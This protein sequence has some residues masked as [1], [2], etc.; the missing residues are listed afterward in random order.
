[1][2]SNS[3][4]S[5]KVAWKYYL[6]FPTILLIMVWLSINTGPWVLTEKPASLL[7]WVHAIRTVFPIVILFIVGIIKLTHRKWKGSFFTPV[8]LWWLYGLIGFFAS[9]FS[10]HPFDAI[11]WAIA[12]LSVFGVFNLF[13]Q[14]KDVLQRAVCLNYLSWFIMTVV[15]AFLFIMAR[16]VM[17]IETPFGLSG[18]EYINIMPTF[19]EMSMSRSTGLARFAAVPGI[20]SFVFLWHGG[21]WRRLFWLAM[22][23]ASGVLIYLMQSR[24][25]FFG[26]VSALSFVMLFLDRKSRRIGAV[27]LIFSI[28]FLY[29]DIIPIQLVKNAT[30]FILRGENTEELITS[31]SGRTTTWMIAWEEVKKSPI[32]GWGFQSDRFLLEQH[33]HNTY[34]Y[35]LMTAGFVGAF[36]FVGGLLKAWI[37]FFQVLRKGIAERL[38]QKIFLIQV[39]GLLAFFTVRSIPE[40]SGAM[41]GIDLMIMLPIMAYLEILN[42]Y[43]S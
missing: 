16:H 3:Y 12:Y 25:A 1:M 11:Y 5:N 34:L 18:Y 19:M 22:F 35:A 40:V 26:F 15:L 30:S 14:G 31:M 39:G 2:K 27:S 42:R 23:V 28:L 37:I 21:I 36:A 9:L 4:I 13:L 33:V 32:F 29:S 38:N 20:I 41:F 8:N 7:G 10:P 6:S 17:F 43:K 24:G